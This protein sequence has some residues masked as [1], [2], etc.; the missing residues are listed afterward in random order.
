MFYNCECGAKFS[1]KSAKMCKKCA[2]KKN[3]PP[4][5]DWP[6]KEELIKMISNSTISKVADQL[7]VSASAVKKRIK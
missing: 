2:G 4:K 1:T 6:S 3:S 7:G 5:I